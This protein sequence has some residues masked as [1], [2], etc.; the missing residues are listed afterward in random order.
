MSSA[1]DGKTKLIVPSPTNEH[2][3]GSACR[4]PAKL[5]HNTRFKTLGNMDGAPQANSYGPNQ[6]TALGHVSASV[7]FFGQTPNRTS[8]N[9]GSQT[10]GTMA[11]S[12]CFRPSSP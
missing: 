5:D 11:V 9:S 3:I 2:P 7:G 6:Y 8:A 4:C 1:S 12:M 10:D